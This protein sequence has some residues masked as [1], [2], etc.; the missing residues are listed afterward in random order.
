MFNQ[1]GGSF[2]AMMSAGG[3][4]ICA[5][6]GDVAGQALTAYIDRQRSPVHI[7]GP[8]QWTCFS[9]EANCKN[10]SRTVRV[11]VNT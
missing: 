6:L 11:E 8:Y 5:Y 7:A 10:P 2:Q 3:N 9:Y 1:T 4:Q